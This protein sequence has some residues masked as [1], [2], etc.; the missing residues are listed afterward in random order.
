[1]EAVFPAWEKFR[2]HTAV[3]YEVSGMSG[4]KTENFLDSVQNLF[5]HFHDPI[6][7]RYL[8]DDLV[9]SD[10][11]SN[12]TVKDLLSESAL[13]LKEG[14][15]RDS[16]VSDVYDL[17]SFFLPRI[18]LVHLFFHLLYQKLDI[19]VQRLE[20]EMSGQLVKVDESNYNN[21]VKVHLKQ[22]PTELDKH[23]TLKFLFEDLLDAMSE[24]DYEG[25]MHIPIR[26]VIYPPPPTP[27]SS[28]STPSGTNPTQNPTQNPA[29]TEPTTKLVQDNADSAYITSRR[30]VKVKALEAQ[31][32]ALDVKTA[33]IRKRISEA[34]K[35]QDLRNAI[36]GLNFEGS[37]TSDV[38][39]LMKVLRR[40]NEA[41]QTSTSLNYLIKMVEKKLLLKEVL[42]DGKLRNLLNRHAHD[43]I[44]NT[45]QQSV[46]ALI[47]DC[48]RLLG[49]RLEPGQKERLV[50]INHLMGNSRP[51]GRE[52]STNIEIECPQSL[53]HLEAHSK[54][55]LTVMKAGLTKLNSSYTSGLVRNSKK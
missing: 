27:E 55:D 40:R 2:F 52:Y 25:P 5:N 45:D 24:A 6:T 30:P 44:R 42:D 15:S 33:A 4:I 46:F 21:P 34:E 3:P 19:T 36:E 28:E 49:M 50:E 29:K 26:D 43:R 7:I 23:T 11:N 54:L 41:R 1:M 32:R 31:F 8:F 51:Y 16:T 13:P 53:I 38:Q 20:S 39:R 9:D 18:E 35:D 47:D 22:L 10:G 12:K 14:A 17:F 48:E 37:K